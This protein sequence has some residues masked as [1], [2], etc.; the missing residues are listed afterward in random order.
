LC[1]KNKFSSRLIFSAF[2]NAR[3]FPAPFL[4]Q[5]KVESDFKLILLSRP[6]QAFITIS[7][8]FGDNYFKI[9]DIAVSRNFDWVGMSLVAVGGVDVS[10]EQIA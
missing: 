4:R 5:Q 2:Q 6:S 9:C 7:V 10:L 3:K 8:R 1:L